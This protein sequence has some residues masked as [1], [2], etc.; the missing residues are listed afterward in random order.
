MLRAMTRSRLIQVW[1]ATILVVVLAAVALGV[2][3]TLGTGVLLFALSL[4]PPAI[5][6]LLWPGIQP[7]TAADVLY[8]RDRRG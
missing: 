3:V 1:F 8:D 5:A 6:L 7:M 4:V 2:T